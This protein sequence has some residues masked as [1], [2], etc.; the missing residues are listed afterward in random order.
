MKAF[1]MSLA[2]LVVVTGAAYFALQPVE[3]PA[4]EAF[5]TDNVRL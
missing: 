4:W 3:E 1:L 2:L 5:K